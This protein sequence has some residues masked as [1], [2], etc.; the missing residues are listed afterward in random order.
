MTK[1]LRLTRRL[2][3]ALTEEA[4]R[5]LRRFSEEAELSTDEAL[6]FLFENFNSVTDD[7]TL[8]HRLRLF[9]ADL[10]NRKR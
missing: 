4:F 2:P 6:V 3:V 1:R 9:K 7:E 5:K 8:P 10:V